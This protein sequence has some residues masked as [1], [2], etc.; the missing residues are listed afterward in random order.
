METRHKALFSYIGDEHLA[1]SAT[2][3][4]EDLY[5][6]ISATSGDKENC[7]L[8][9]SPMEIRPHC[10]SIWQM[11]RRENCSWLGLLNTPQTMIST[12]FMEL[13]REFS[14]ICH[15]K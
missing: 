2:C 14:T 10:C 9:R 1:T 3:I 11:K 12:D 15:K 7:F 6:I 8:R 5:L 13:I 4:C